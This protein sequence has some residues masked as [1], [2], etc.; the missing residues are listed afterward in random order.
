MQ[1]L[2]T[3]TR[4]FSS[5]IRVQIQISLRIGTFVLYRFIYSCLL[6]E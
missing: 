1:V 4:V 2:H 3:L 5:L 6:D